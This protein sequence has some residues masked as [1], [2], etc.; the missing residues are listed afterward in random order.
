MYLKSIFEFDINRSIEGVIKADD[1]AKLKTEIDEYVLTKEIEKRL[2][3]FFHSYNNYQNSNGVWISGFFGS[4]KSHLL[5]MLSLLLE[6]RIIEGESTLDCFLKKCKDNEI[7]KA[8]IK[9]A[10][11]IPSKSILFNIDQKADVI[12]KNQL[13]ALLSVFSKVFNDMCGYYGKQGHIS[14]FER[15]LDSRGLYEKF[16][17]EY[18]NIS[19]LDWERGREQALL[20]NK[21]ITKAYSN[22]TDSS[23]DSISGILDKYRSEYKLSI[24]DF[25]SQVN[26][27]IQKQEKGFR[28]NFFV[29]EVGQ[30]IANNEKLMTNL[31]TIAESLATK[32]NG[33]A[34]IIVTAQDDMTN[35]I[36]EMTK[37]QGL[38]FSKIQARFSTRMK[39][40][41]QDVAE[42]I[43]K[44]LLA[45][46]ETGKKLVSDLYKEQ[47]GNFKT[48]FD[49]SDG[50]I[51]YRN[52][53]DKEHFINSYPFI[54]YQFDL[55][56]SA[57]QSISN[58]NA[59]EG[60]HSSVGERSM[61]GVFQE[62]AIKISEKKVEDLATFDLMFEGVRSFLKSNIQ[63]S[64]GL[65]ENNLEN[66]LSIKLLKVLF[67]VKYVKEF[68]PTIRNLCILMESSFKEDINSL[69][70]KVEESLSLLEQ[71][72]Y[73]KRNGELYEFLT[74]E[75]K[76][77]EQEIK[78]TDV[79]SSDILEEI[80]EIIFDNIIKNK[81]IRYI[82][83]GQDYSFSRRIDNKL[84]GRDSELCINVITPF[85][86]YSS[87]EDIIMSHSLGKSELT[88]ILP[89]EHKIVRE[90]T[91]YKRTE[92]YIR[93]NTTISQKE[94]VSKIIMEKSHNNSDRRK[95]IER[96]LGNLLTKSTILIAG[97]K[98]DLLN[99]EPVG[100]INQA[101]Y[102]L[103]KRTYP[104]L[105]M[106]RNSRFKEE[107]IV[108][109]LKQS[110]ETLF[111]N[112]TIE[113]SEAEQE[114]Q[115]FIQANILYGTRTTLK[116]LIDK[117]EM[118][119][120]G[121]S[122]SAILCILA[123]LCSRERIEVRSDGNLLEGVSL[124]KALKNTHEYNNV[125]LNL[126]IEF[127]VAQIR[128][129][130]DFYEEFSDSP[131]STSEAKL[132]AKEL[133][134]VINKKIEYFSNLKNKENNY[135]FI[136]SIDRVI[137]DLKEVSN[138]QYS[139][140]LTD[141][142]NKSDSL[143]DLKES[144]IEPIEK[145]MMSSSKNIYDEAKS[146]VLENDAN[147]VYIH[148]HQKEKIQ[149]LLLDENCFKS[150]KVQEIK[151]LL[152]ELKTII[153]DKLLEVKNEQ[154]EEI[155]SL[156]NHILELNDFKALD[157]N[158]KLQITSKFDNIIETISNQKIFAVIYDSVR[159]FKD[160]D[161][162][163]ILEN[164]EF[165]N[166]PIEV[167]TDEKK[168]AN[169][170]SVKENPIE[171][172]TTKDLKLGFKKPWI[173]DRND[174]DEYLNSLRNAMEKEL[175]LGKRVRI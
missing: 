88:I 59:F 147:F 2:E 117:F 41:S 33:Q 131:S 146:F 140:Y 122:Q 113:I 106:L 6:N 152:N 57:I 8:D 3:N 124:E 109:F 155:N 29:D 78:N 21:N 175:V 46:N 7:L 44:R 145:F 12:S 164:I 10:T 20:E 114:V 141:F 173:A 123:K 163:Q 9:K 63:S 53:K 161:Y 60:K 87:K 139:Y 55:F 84:F 70:E 25:A 132:L 79:E 171:Y 61:L 159:R 22:I 169:I 34:W 4:G 40:T 143:L 85:Y 43:Q 128:Q 120:Y 97:E 23:D 89:Q 90:I 168:D 119:P 105:K 13:D 167:I 153:Q 125:I 31:Q 99:N 127:T 51:S 115:S 165:W 74:D 158:K 134:D 94:S 48:L 80:S 138:K 77:I 16:K 81:K 136:N 129:L 96:Q 93:Q 86:E 133:S 156:L 142:R 39:L 157:E 76:D 170:Q 45:K 67:L 121:W 49:F 111:G 107:D 42:V 135:P 160:R 19:K 5:K 150:I 116:N 149:S 17:I 68:K 174:L 100:L 108:K 64:I 162:H 52:F 72:T 71:Q 36:G 137:N 112:D 130:K 172:I 26:E 66:E 75:E 92:K 18:K 69:R 58:H 28:L 103:I 1:N 166:R 14:K 35:V 73:I 30:Y 15:D 50:S 91:M 101:F 144:I 62:V 37:K 65:A 54:P 24:E 38:D 32:C 118:K 148:S 27:Y 126:Q 98:T 95:E 154:K 82:E 56:Q 11:S 83:N 104:N 47:K 151:N 110:K 102:E